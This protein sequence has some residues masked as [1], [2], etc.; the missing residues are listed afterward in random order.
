MQ[1]V[2]VSGLGLF[3]KWGGG[4][5]GGDGGGGCMLLKAT[6]IPKSEEI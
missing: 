5:G 1:T 4:G 2:Y 6:V 3:L